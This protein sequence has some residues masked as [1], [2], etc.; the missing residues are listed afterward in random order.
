MYPN[1]GDPPKDINNNSFLQI[2]RAGGG[3][4]SWN[5][6]RTLAASAFGQ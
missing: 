1:A 3:R 4:G 2:T 5:H 6:A